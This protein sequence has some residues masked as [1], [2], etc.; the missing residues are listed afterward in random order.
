MP[1]SGDMLVKDQKEFRSQESEARTKASPP[2]HESHLEDAPDAVD[3]DSGRSTP[4]S[5]SNPQ[6]GKAEGTGVS[7][8]GQTPQTRRKYVR[9][10]ERTAC[11]CGFVSFPG[12]LNSSGHRRSAVHRHSKQL[13]DLL[14][15]EGVSFQEIG[16]RLKITRE[17]VRQIANRLGYPA[18]RV[19]QKARA[20]RPGVKPGGEAEYDAAFK[21]KWDLVVALRA[22][23]PYPV[24]SV[25]DGLRFREVRI[26]GTVCQ[27][28]KADWRGTLGFTHLGALKGVTKAR[29][30]L[31]KLPQGGWLVIPR[32]KYRPGNIKLGEKG[33]GGP[34]EDEQ[35][36]HLMVNN[37]NL[38]EEMKAE[39]DAA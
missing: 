2:P 35:E 6:A 3:S 13:K 19:R 21:D 36:Y 25:A 7:E 37:W 4:D 23:C 11:A 18:G 39:V 8:P 5:P 27:V 33:K 26:L 24:D 1:E 12:Y 30:V 17:R 31:L 38:L 20:V 14:A 10:A 9:R 15:T 28:G 16:R 29:V 32:E 34:H 22:E